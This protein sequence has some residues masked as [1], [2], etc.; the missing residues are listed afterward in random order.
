MGASDVVITVPG[1]IRRG[2]DG[3]IYRGLLFVLNPVVDSY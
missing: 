3:G 2:S 1:G